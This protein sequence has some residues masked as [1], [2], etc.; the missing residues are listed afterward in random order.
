MRRPKIAAAVAMC[1]T[2]LIPVAFVGPAASGATTPGSAIP[3]GF[4]AQSVNW[5]S[6]A[7]GWML[8]VAPCG[9]STCTTVDG[10]TNG[11]ATWNEL[12]TLNAPLIL[13]QSNG[14]TE[15]RFADDLHGWAFGPAL[16]AT[17]NGGTTWK[18]QQPPGGGHR[19]L[20]LAGDSDAVYAV[21]TPC[22][23]N[24]VCHDPAT[25]WRTSAGGGTWTQVSV[26]LPVS[27]DAV[28]AVHGIA[29]YAVVQSGELDP[30][31][32]DVTV[33]GQQW[34]SRPDPCDKAK[35]EFLTDVAPVTDTKVALLCVANIGLSQAIKGVFRSNDNGQ[36]T[37]AAAIT[38]WDGIT[39][40][41]AAAPNGTLVVSSWGAAGSWI[42]RNTGGRTWTTP[43]AQ[44]DGG[45]GWN[46]V[47]F[48]TNEVG[49]VVYGPAAVYPGNRA[50]Q[51]WETQDGG[52]TWAPV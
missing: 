6:P 17:R 35:N 48:T 9:Q 2:I 11:G 37:S 28:L 40:E 16:W 14:I 18:R 23:I 52:V 36:T 31:A 29:A 8:G 5:V 47:V 13:E 32:L 34:S 27:T 22:R 51:L 46:D 1:F 50:G 24:H 30:D 44:A 33:D 38:P 3:A 19:V 21:V 15:I 4:R 10:T 20:A 49:F 7:H 45:E 42:Y 39:S 43:V 12:G 26:M 41:L 25:L